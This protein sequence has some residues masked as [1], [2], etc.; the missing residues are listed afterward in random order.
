MALTVLRRDVTMREVLLDWAFAEAKSQH[1]REWFRGQPRLFPLVEK[2]AADVPLTTTEEDIVVGEGWWRPGFSDHFKHHATEWLEGTLDA[3]DLGERRLAGWTSVELRRPGWTQVRT[4]SELLA[5]Q[6]GGGGGYRIKDYDVAL[7]R[8]HLILVGT[9][10][11]LPSLRLMEGT[12]R[13]CER[14]MRLREGLDDGPARVFVG[15]CAMAKGW[16]Y[17]VE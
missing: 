6:G 11:A 16:S 12:H 15:V 14:T 10:A 5:S 2:M 17:W 4:I 7:D 1:L 8:E 13:A 3:T 9:D